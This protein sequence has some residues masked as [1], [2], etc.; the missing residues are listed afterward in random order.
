M[1]A[2]PL[3]YVVLGHRYV[4]RPDGVLQLGRFVGGVAGSRDH[5][6]HY[7]RRYGVR[8]RLVFVMYTKEKAGEPIFKPL[9]DMDAIVQV[10]TQS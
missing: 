7:G 6:Y 1:P 3:G 8:L 10:R 5:R 4:A 9:V 2:G